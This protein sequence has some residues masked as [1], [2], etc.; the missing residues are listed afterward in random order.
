MRL[1]AALLVAIAFAPS[2]NAWSPFGPKNYD[3]CVLKNTKGVTDKTILGVIL[4][5]CAREFP[6][7]ESETVASCKERELTAFEKSKIKDT[8][9][10]DHTYLFI[11]VKIYNGN[12]KTT[13]ND[14]SLYI[15]DSNIDP[16]QVYKLHIGSYPL[17][18][19]EPHSTGK[20]TTTI[21]TKP[22]GN[23]KLKMDLILL[24][25]CD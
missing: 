18:R 21:F 10:S 16:P 20:A 25:T 17:N 11:T 3:Q 14:A 12:A 8:I 4:N 7:S 15:S 23:G 24:K 13:L 22:E 5:S 1:I 6:N 2:A 9:T 19:I